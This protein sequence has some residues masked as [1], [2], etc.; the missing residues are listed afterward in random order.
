MAKTKMKKFSFEIFPNQNIEENIKLLKKIEKKNPIFI[1]IT[2]GKNDNFEFIKILKKNTLVK[3][4]P[5]IVCD[6]IYYVIVKIINFIKIKIYNF[7]IITGDNIK[8]N[9]FIFIKIIRKLF[10]HIIKIFSGSYFEE[11]KITNNMKKEIF[12]IYKKKKNGINLFL[13]QFFY[14]FNIINYYINKLKKTGINKNFVPGIFPK[15][16]IKEILLFA[17][18][19]KIELPIWIIKNYYFINI[20]NYYFKNLIHYKHFHFYTFN[21]LELINFY[22]K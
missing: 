22:L 12:F 5:H 13:T 17:N 10:G 18:K 2:C 9:S 14:N 7:I 19:T 15:K 8:N 21:K 20:K 6:N 4:I 16:N 1:S 3:L 11:H